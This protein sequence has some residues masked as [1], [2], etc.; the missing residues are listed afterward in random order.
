[1]YFYGY[2]GVKGG[3][4][5]LAKGMQARERRGGH[6][7]WL[8]VSPEGNPRHAEGAQAIMAE[9]QGNFRLL[10]AWVPPDANW[11]RENVCPEGPLDFASFDPD[12]ETPTVVLLRL[13][14]TC[15]PRLVM[16][17][18][19]GT[20]YW[21]DT[22]WQLY[23]TRMLELARAGVGKY[24]LVVDDEPSQLEIRTREPAHTQ[25]THQ[26]RRHSLYMLV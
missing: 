19:S 20:Y 2:P 13:L 22:L 9:F 15:T 25:K 16:I 3:T 24:V 23:Q 8:L 1:M 21:R 14:E 18:Q 6:A 4:Y 7:D 5:W 11:V 10:E 17:D 26:R 12:L